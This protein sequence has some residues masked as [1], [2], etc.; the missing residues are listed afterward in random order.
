MM[1][2]KTPTGNEAKFFSMNK[3][4][5]NETSNFNPVGNS[6]SKNK[7]DKDIAPTLKNDLSLCS[8]PSVSDI[9]IPKEKK[10]KFI[11]KKVN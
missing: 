11:L 2:E 8:L 1:S 9:E 7:R 3:I 5:S 10:N 4:L 6:Q